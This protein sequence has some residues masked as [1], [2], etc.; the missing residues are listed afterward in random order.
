MEKVGLTQWPTI[1]ALDGVCR[2]H[3]PSVPLKYFF[4]A[5]NVYVTV[6]ALHRRNLGR[7]DG[8]AKT[9]QIAHRR[10]YAFS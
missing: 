5:D 8:E 6:R 2:V 1:R 3:T 7:V 10:V 4:R 9:E